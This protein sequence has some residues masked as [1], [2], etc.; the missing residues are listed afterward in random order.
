MKNKKHIELINKI[1]LEKFNEDEFLAMKKF[2][3]SE[4]LD[5]LILE[6]TTKE[7]I[8]Y[9]SVYI[10]IKLTELLDGLMSKTI[11]NMSKK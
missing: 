3:E 4:K 5:K 10:Q 2:I 11:K 8:F 9:F 6:N 1:L 7:E